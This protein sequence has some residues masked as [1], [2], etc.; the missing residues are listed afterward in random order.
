MYDARE[1]TS[2]DIAAWVDKAKSDPIGYVERQATEVFL[3][4]LGMAEPYCDKILLKGGILMGVVYSSPRQTGDIDFTSIFDP[5]SDIADNIWNS[6]TSALPRASAAL[7]YP[8]L[9]CRVQNVKHRPRRESFAAAD[10]P[11][12]EVTIGY[13]RRGSPEEKRLKK[14]KAPKVLR[15]DISF[16]EPV[17]SIQ[18][19]RL[20]KDGP[21]IRAYSLL[22]LIAEK[23]RALLQQEIRNRYRR[24]DIYD[25]DLLLKRFPLDHDEQV[26]LLA[27]FFEKCRARGIEPQPDSLERPEVIRRA[28]SEWDTLR[29]ELGELPVFESCYLAV[30]TFFRGLPWSKD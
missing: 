16:R 24:Q 21:R 9:I 17:G 3:A 25:I 22:D 30:N 15:A 18:V 27:L 29:L 4:A 8:D 2:V 6:L 11:A 28:A 5:T 23:L 1:E 13:A 19:V 10:G 26:R 12:L 20:G 14:G 7:G